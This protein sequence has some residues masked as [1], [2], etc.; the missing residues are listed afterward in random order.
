MDNIT[1]NITNN[2]YKPLNDLCLKIIDKHY[3]RTDRGK[4]LLVDTYHTEGLYVD[5][6]ALYNTLGVNHQNIPQYDI[7][8][9]LLKI[10][11]EYSRMINLINTIL[12]ITGD[13][14]ACYLLSVNGRNV[15][16]VNRAKNRFAV[17]FKDVEAL[18]SILDEI[19]EY[20]YSGVSD[21]NVYA[22]QAIAYIHETIIDMISEV[23]VWRDEFRSAVAHFE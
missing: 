21:A 9:H 12:D 22:I 23:K 14:A 6:S 10:N 19:I 3:N 18:E 13:G 20:Y 11:I 7:T 8:A 16:L 4:R 17:F 15:E 5:L 2:T 1:N